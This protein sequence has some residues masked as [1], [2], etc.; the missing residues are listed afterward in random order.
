ML[1]E[2]CLFLVI[3]KLVCDGGHFEGFSTVIQGDNA[4]PHQDATF[5]KYVVN[6]CKEK[7]WL[8]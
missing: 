4:V 2:K 6:L 3:E 1:F 5:Y 8:W 7:K